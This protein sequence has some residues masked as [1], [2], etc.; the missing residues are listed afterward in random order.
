MDYKKIV[1]NRLLDKYERSKAYLDGCSVRRIMLKLCSGDMPEYNLEDT[2]VRELVNSMIQD[3][4]EDGIVKFEWMRFE[5][6]NIIDRVWLCLDKTEHAY[7]EAGRVPKKG[8]ADL[9]LKR[10]REALPGITQPWIEDFFKE[11]LDF[12][13][14]KKS[15]TPYLPGDT[16]TALAVLKALMAIDSL[17]GEECPERVFSIKCFG[18][19]KY[20]E[21]YVKKRV[22]GIIRQYLVKEGDFI[23]RPADDEMLAQVG[24][25]KAFEQVEFCGNVSGRLYG[26]PV[27]FSTF[28]HGIAINSRTVKDLEVTGIGEVKKVLFIENRTNYMKYVS[29]DKAGDQLVIFHGGFYSPAKG[30]FFQ[31]VYEAGQR[32]GAEFYHWGDIDIGGFRMFKRLKENIIPGL[33]PYLMD[34]KAF[35]SKEKYW[36]PFN[37]K[38]QKALERMLDDKGYSEFHKVIET[39][40]QV[41]ARLEQ[42]AFL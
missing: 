24:I 6:G 1:L 21:R 3:L 5:R 30:V 34:R 11:A 8:K 37:K 33:K 15:I 35:M 39:M 12:I 10:I 40:L 4:A 9:V 19:S 29:T 28:R 18:D 26:K 36:L 27:D 2:P 17:D 22:A 16:G 32:A 42:E 38:Y 13:D 20:F 23:E 7:R 14:A 41:R 25:V 31:K